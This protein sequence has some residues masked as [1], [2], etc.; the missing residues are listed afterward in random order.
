[1]GIIQQR[2]SAFTK[3][4]AF[5]SQFSQNKIVKKENIEFNDLFF[6]GFKHQ[7][8]IAQEHNSWFTKDN[9]LFSIENWSKALNEKDLTTWVSTETLGKNPS[10]KIAI[11]MAGNIPLV[12]FHDFLAVLISGHN[13]V[14][15]QSSNDEHLL[16][17]LAKYLEYVAPSLKGNILFTKDKLTNFDAVIA[18]G[19]NNTARYFEYYFKDKPSIIRKNR[20]SCAI[21]TG[22]ENAE[23]FKNLSEDIFRYF[24]LGCR[25]V[26]KLF[27]PKG[28]NFDPFFKGMFHQQEIINNAK[29]ANNYDYNKAV[30]LMSEFD[31]LENGFLMIKE[32]Q[33]YSSPIASIFYEYYDNIDNLKIKLYEEREKI[34][35]VVANNFIENEIPFG[36]TQHPKLSDYADGVNTLKFLSEL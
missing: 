36:Q 22:N 8:K 24:G 11:I 19:S 2:I 10:K 4:G 20:N 17:F 32:D 12:G 28:Y 9:I 7:I 23:D 1:M 14:V 29:Y 26:S 13:V 6:D 35:C 18:T 31:I 30:Y 34:Q 25:N 27:I 33:S 5:L 16:P 15:K 21:I 3:L